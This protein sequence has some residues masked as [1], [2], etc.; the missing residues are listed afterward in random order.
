M[1]QEQKIQDW[2]AM[3]VLEIIGGE[4]VNIVKDCGTGWS[5]ESIIYNY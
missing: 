3:V 1:H 2:A 4:V 5:T